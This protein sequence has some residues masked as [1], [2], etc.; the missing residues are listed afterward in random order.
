M[1]ETQDISVDKLFTKWF[2]R[3]LWGNNID[4]EF[5]NK[6]I[7]V[8]L[9]N[10]WITAR[11]GFKTILDNENG[12]EPQWI[13]YNRQSDDLIYVVDGNIYSVDPVAWTRTLLQNM[14]AWDGEKARFI[15]YGD[16][17][18]VLTG[19]QKPYYY[20]WSTAWQATTWDNAEF[21]ALFQRFTFVNKRDNPNVLYV[22]A[23]IDNNNQDNCYN[24]DVSGTW[25]GYT[26]TF[27]GK[28]LGLTATMSRLWIFTDQSIEYFSTQW[29]DQE[30]WQYVPRPFA[31]WEDV[32]SPDCVVGAWEMVFYLTKGKNIRTIGYEGTAV[33]PQ[34]RTISDIS[35]KSIK[36][37]LEEEI[38]DDQSKAF[39]DYDKKNN[40]VRFWLVGKN[41]TRPNVCLIRDI[42][43]RTWIQDMDKGFW[44]VCSCGKNKF[45]ISSFSDVVYQD[46]IGTDDDWETIDRE[47]E[48]QALTLWD[49]YSVKQFR[50]SKISGQIGNNVSIG[51]DIYVDDELVFNKLI[52]SSIE[53][54][55][56]V[57]WIGSYWLWE[58]EVWS[59]WGWGEI[60][61]FEKNIT[62]WRLRRDWKKIRFNFFWGQY[63]NDWLLDWLMV[64]VRP[65]RKTRFKD[66]KFI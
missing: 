9:V 17:T 61:D 2:V 20:D 18:I 24:W 62:I 29:V 39:G 7:N 35:G 57:G 66:K 48:T 63:S 32:V 60:V 58:E 31:R 46:D 14:T 6:A 16:Y 37:F 42:V 3:D 38:A 47:F 54:P 25:D 65:R 23:P 59:W 5:A 56:S 8:R 13:E 36:W 1:V 34:I 12:N 19:D 4:S 55:T 50:W 22:S 53:N 27:P 33:E 43:H 30:T 44:A 15:T 28:I 41:S 52:D 21:G 11:K 49:P 10:G 26:V 45:A 64:S 40:L 51:V